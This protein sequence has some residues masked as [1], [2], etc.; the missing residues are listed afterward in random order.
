MKM[1][2][3]DKFFAWRHKGEINQMRQVM[4]VYTLVFLVWAIYRQLF[5]LPTWFEEVFLK[6]IVFGLPVFWVVLKREKKNLESL[7]MVTKGLLISIYLGLLLGLWMAVLGNIVAFFREGGVVFN[8]D[9]GVKEFGDLMLLGLVTAFWE[10]LLFMGYML[11]RVVK[12]LGGDELV[13]VGFVAVLFA[14]I[15][16]PIQIS[17]GVELAQIFLRFI[18]L[19]SLGFGNGVLYLRFKNLAAPIFAHLAW[20]SVIYLF[21]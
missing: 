16:V 20:G 9:L 18:L 15:H 13:G 21:G 8:Q 11:P 10:E 12:N 5:F 2:L 3:S 7:G 19:F 4:W 14:L 6:A 17:E 1:G